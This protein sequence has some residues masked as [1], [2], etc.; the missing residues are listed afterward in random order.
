VAGGLLVDGGMTPEEYQ[1]RR[2]Q[3]LAGG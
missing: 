2:N 3:I 1:A